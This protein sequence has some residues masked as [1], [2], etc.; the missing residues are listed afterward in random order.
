[1]MPGASER[2]YPAEYVAARAV[3]LDA[4]Q[5]L[6][7]HLPAIIVV[8]AQAVYTHTGAGEFVEQPMTTDCDLALNVGALGE[9]PEITAALTNANFT[10]GPNPGSWLGAGEV[11]V[12]IMVT[13][14]QSGRTKKKARAAR[15]P[16]HGE[17]AARITP[18]LEPAVV[19]HASQMLETLDPSDHRRVEVNVAGP[20]ALF[21]AKAIKIEDRLVDA[22][23]AA[24]RVKEKDALDM[25]R[26]LQA[27]ETADLVTGLRRHLAD[28]DARAISLRALNFLEQAG[29]NASSVLPSLAAGAAAG[30][31]TVAA[32]FAALTQTLLAAVQPIVL[33]DGGPFGEAS[34]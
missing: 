13:P 12:D 15:L 4:L 23:T 21:V 24:N 14:S 11:A 17:W 6:D 32:S 7:D 9:E 1:M 29:T 30:D 5:A 10:P 27:V 28:H 8:G 31:R 20:A 2:G 18:G 22:R 33:R 19:D 3:L 26:L 34:R 16:G 25:L